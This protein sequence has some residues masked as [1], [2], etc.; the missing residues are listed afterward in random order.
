MDERSRKLLS[1]QALPKAKVPEPK[2]HPRRDFKLPE[3][4]R[5]RASSPSLDELRAKS[6]APSNV[7]SPASMR[8]AEGSVKQAAPLPPLPKPRAATGSVPPPASQAVSP[9][10]LALPRGMTPVEMKWPAIG[11]PAP[12]SSSPRIPLPGVTPLAGEAPAAGKGK[13]QS[14]AQ[15]A[16]PA[17][18][19]PPPIP[20]LAKKEVASIKKA[21]LPKLVPF[22]HQATPAPLPPPPHGKQP[23]LVVASAT[24]QGF[25]EHT[26]MWF[27]AGDDE[28]ARAVREAEED[29]AEGAMGMLSGLS[30]THWIIAAAVVAAI[31]LAVVLL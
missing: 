14:A 2:S 13:R 21:K 7:P 9:P 28:A 1:T 26:S 15:P 20:K 11:T 30:R 25:R 12:A 10:A 8:L 5:G 6:L 31:V 17:P 27:K 4:V 18:P 23:A 16:Q 3:G 22:D 19:I 24:E 29:A